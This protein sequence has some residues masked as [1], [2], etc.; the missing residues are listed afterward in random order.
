MPVSADTVKEVRERT[1]AGILECKIALEEANGDVEAAIGALRQKGVAKGV[2]LAGRKANAG[3]SQGVVESYVHQGGRI[4]VLLELN[5]ETDFV[6]RTDDFRHLAHDIALQIAAMAPQHV[7]LD[8]LPED[9]DEETRENSLWNQQFIRDP[10]K[11]I[12]DLVSEAI[13]K[14]GE[15]IRVSRFARYELGGA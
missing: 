15:N 4:G 9:A 3:L 12:K 11:T 13:G 7:G 14:L 1:G 6:A 2:K 8:D 10:S 5:C